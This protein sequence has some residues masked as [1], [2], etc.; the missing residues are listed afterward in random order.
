M[1]SLI[2]RA[3]LFSPSCVSFFPLKELYN[4]DLTKGAIFTFGFF[5][6][7]QQKFEDVIRFFL[8]VFHNLHS[9]RRFVCSSIS[10]ISFLLTLIYFSINC[11]IS[12]LSSP[13]ET[14]GSTSLA[15]LP[16]SNFAF[17]E[18]DSLVS[19]DFLFHLF[20]LLSFVLLSLVLFS[21]H[22]S[23]FSYNES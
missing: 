21:T 8:S 12:L 10:F 18:L 22:F 19:F 6:H 5:L 11:S 20:S 2:A 4:I 13:A 15:P 23:L 9:D 17:L 7:T 16:Y 3:S 14:S 1:Y